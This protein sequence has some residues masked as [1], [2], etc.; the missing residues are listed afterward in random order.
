VIAGPP[1]RDCQDPRLTANIA[2]LIHEA[3]NPYYDWLYGRPSEARRAVDWQLRL[4]TSEISS[5]RVTALLKDAVLLGMYVALN[6]AEL[7]RARMTDAMAITRREGTRGPPSPLLDRIAESRGLFAPVHDDEF[8][9]SKF[10][11][12]R[13]FRG[14]GWGRLVLDDYIGAGRRAGFTRFRLDVSADNAA[15]IAL[16]QSAG[17]IIE[18]TAERAGMTYAAMA[19]GSQETVDVGRPGSR[20]MIC[21]GVYPEIVRITDPPR[22]RVMVQPVEPR[23]AVAP[24]SR[25]SASS[26]SSTAPIVRATGLDSSCSDHVASAS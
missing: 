4:P 13:R 7:A 10:G 8:Y 20:I 2:A 18:S 19:L 11:V 14:R 9:L 17:F 25:E 15:A 1:P 12:A 16:Y 24:L 3:G 23:G 5:T 26:R 22:R 6:G 21:P